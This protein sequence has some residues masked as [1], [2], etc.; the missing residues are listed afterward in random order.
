[1][2][3]VAVSTM[4]FAAA[5]AGGLVLFRRRRDL[6]LGYTLWV[7][8]LSPELRRIVDYLGTRSSFNPIMIAPFAVSAISIWTVRRSIVSASASTRR[9]LLLLSAGL[10]YAFAIGIFHAGPLAAVYDLLNWAVPVIFGFHLLLD[11]E[12]YE[13]HRLVLQRTFLWGVLVLGAYGAVQFFFLPPWDREWMWKSGMLSIGY[14][15]PFHVRVFSAMNSPGPFATLLLAG[16]LILPTISGR[17]RWPAASLGYAAFALALVRAA[18][19]GWFLAAG[20]LVVNAAR[21]HRLKLGTTI[22]LMCVTAIPVLAI[23][24]ETIS[25]GLT[26]AR[27]LVAP[28]PPAPLE[29][30]RAAPPVAAP[31]AIAPSAPVEASQ[32]PLGTVGARVGSLGTLNRDHSFRERIAFYRSAFDQVRAR[33]LGNG[34][35]STGLAV[36]LTSVEALRKNQDFD[37]GVMNLPFVLGWPGTLL[38]LGGLGMLLLQLGRGHLRVDPLTSAM[39]GIAC[40]ILA[41]V[42]FANVLTGSTGLLLWIFLAMS[43]AAPARRPAVAA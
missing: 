7:W 43:L 15:S 40:A 6:Y 41:Q 2:I 16:L 29:P 23:G 17:L 38:F 35:G 37:S 1:M 34:L 12:L 27:K 9:A 31:P 26:L 20:L 13:R 14:P 42:V 24:P 3:T 21:G 10:L 36:K 19:G 33:P 8:F 4:C 32:A 39:L 28:P 25:T 22:A 18:W 30:P 5:F 11:T